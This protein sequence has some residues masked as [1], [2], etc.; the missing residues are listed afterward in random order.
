MRARSDV[1]R[2]TLV[3][4]LVGRGSLSLDAHQAPCHRLYSCPSDHGTYVCGDKGRCDQCPDNQYCLAG[5]PRMASAPT[6]APAQPS[7]AQCDHHARGGNG[8]LHP[9]WQLH[10]CHCARPG[11]CQAHDPG[12]SLL[13]F[14]SAPLAK[15]LLD[16]HTRGVQ[17]HVILEKSQRTEKYAPADFLVNQWVP[18][19]IDAEHAIAH[20]KL[21][22]IDGE[23]AI[24]GSFNSRHL[25]QC[26]PYNKSRIL[27]S[28][29]SCRSSRLAR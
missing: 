28:T 19:M 6:S 4:L 10:G 22:V 15:A 8:L 14:T 1:C 27:P 7:I 3:V 2:L 20:H 24:S 13:P 11:R 29:C 12:A 5:K 9:W 23:L 26:R 17:V 18:T 16:A 21:I 25:P